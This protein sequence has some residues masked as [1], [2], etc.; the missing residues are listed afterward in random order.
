M[1]DCMRLDQWML[2]EPLVAEF[3][4]IDRHYYFS[5]LAQRHAICAQRAVCRAVSG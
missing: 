5:I 1:V 3:Y 2:V 4:N